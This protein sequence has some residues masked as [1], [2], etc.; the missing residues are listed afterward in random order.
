LSQRGQTFL[1]KD[2]S[3][4]K[5][6]WVFLSVW[7]DQKENKPGILRDGI[8]GVKIAK[9]TETV[10]NEMFVTDTE[11]IFNRN[12]CTT[13]MQ[14]PGLNCWLTESKFLE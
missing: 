11:I 13:N 14:I 9:A 1:G 6:L 10:V 8:P 12:K 2:S 7:A 3:A 4:R 5:C